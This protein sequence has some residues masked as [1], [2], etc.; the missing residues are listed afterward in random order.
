MLPHAGRSVSEEW[1]GLTEDINSARRRIGEIDEQIMKLVC[2]R[3]REAEKIGRMKRDRKVPVRDF[4]VEAQVIERAERICEMNGIPGHIGREVSKS[5]IMASLSVQTSSDISVYEGQSRR[6]L[7]VGGNGKMGRWYAH[8]FNTQGHEVVIN[9]IERVPS[10]FKFE[11]DLLRAVS[12]ADVVILSTPISVTAGIIRQLAEA[13]CGATV[14]DGCSL[15]SPLINEIRFGI[16]RGMRIAS[17]HPMFGPGTRMLVD[18]NLIVCDCGDREAVETA[19][20]LFRDTSLN[21]TVIDIARHDEIMGYALGAAHAINIVFFDMLSRSGI[22]A[23]EMDRFASTTLRRQISTAADVARENPLLYY[24][25]QNLNS[26]R[27]TVFSSLARSL[28]AVRKASFSSSADD[29]IDIMNRGRLY[30]EE[31]QNV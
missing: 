3:I 12:M 7:I 17:I 30:F 16:S 8:Y 11:P 14:I 20:S 5:L 25:I 26:H 27:D 21:I 9:D 19:V 23:A 13:S 6:I 10:P 24:E 18:Q 15:K 28:E 29:F 22:G 2:E 1:I 31:A 4:T